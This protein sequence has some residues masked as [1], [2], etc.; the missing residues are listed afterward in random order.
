MATIEATRLKLAEAQFFYCKLAQAH[1]RLISGEPEAFGFYLSAFIS[2]ARSVTFVL[3]AERKT[4]YD[5]W[6]VDWM[7]ALPEEQQ[8]LL[9]NFNEQRVATVHKKGAAVTGKLEEISQSEFF[10]AVA[11]E[12]AQIQI[13][14]GIPGAPVPAQYRATRSL[15]FGDTEVSAVQASAKYLALLSQLVSSFTERFPDETET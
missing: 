1:E 5:T 9:R 15:V 14:N 12:G 3:Q 10:L 2:A 4:Q 8:S 13:W 6:F 7:D 11:R